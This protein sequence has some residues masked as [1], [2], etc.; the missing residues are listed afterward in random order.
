LTGQ[1]GR[2]LPFLS[3]VEENINANFAAIGASGKN[4]TLESAET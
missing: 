2:A 4:Q 1:G 3:G